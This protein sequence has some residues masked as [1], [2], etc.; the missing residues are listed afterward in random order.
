MTRIAATNLVDRGFWGKGRAALAVRA[1]LESV[2]PISLA[3]VAILPEENQT[4]LRDA[5]NASHVTDSHIVGKVVEA[6]IAHLLGFN[7]GSAADAIQRMRPGKVVHGHLE[8]ITG[9]RTDDHG[10][11]QL[12]Y[13]PRFLRDPADLEA[14]KR[15]LFGLVDRY[16]DEPHYLSVVLDQSASIGKSWTVSERLSDLAVLESARPWAGMVLAEAPPD[17]RWK[18]QKSGSRTILLD[19]SAKIGGSIEYKTDFETDALV[20]EIKHAQA[21]EPIH[22]A[23]ALIY[24]TCLG[25]PGVLVG[26]NTC[27]RASVVPLPIRHLDHLTRAFFALTSGVSMRNILGG[28]GRTRALPGIPSTGV[29]ISLDVETTTDLDGTVLLTEIG[30]VAFDLG[31][32]DLLVDVYHAV[33]PGVVACE[34]AG[35]DE[36]DDEED[37]PAGILPRPPFHLADRDVVDPPFCS[38]PAAGLGVARGRDLVEGQRVFIAAFEDWVARLGPAVL[39]QWAGS[40]TKLLGLATLPTTDMHKGFRWWLEQTGSPRVRHTRLTDAVECVFGP[41]M[42]FAP[43]RAFEDAVMTAAVLVAVQH[44]GL[45]V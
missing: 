35:E 26:T 31:T 8:E 24:A 34:G 7:L 45:V 4:G 17:A 41:E 28:R 38:F 27:S 32:Q 15:A 14:F 42:P 39:V 20:V 23:Q 1:V 33:A 37:A 43:H 19:R 36:E 29:L 12:V 3:P 22:A 10:Q 13:D 30:A 2:S 11:F 6:S 9:L 44:N 18:Y 16:A 5:A 21:L 40:D 25:K